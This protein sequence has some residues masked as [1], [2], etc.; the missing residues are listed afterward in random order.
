MLALWGLPMLVGPCS[1]QKNEDSL[2]GPDSHQQSP[3]QQEHF[4]GELGGKRSQ[5]LQRGVTI[6]LQYIADHLGNVRSPEKKRFTSWNRVRGTVDLDLGKLAG[7]E[8]WTFHITGLWQAGG[9]LGTDLNSIASPSGMSSGSTFRL[10]SYWVE[11]RWKGERI[12]A[13]IGQFAGQDFY[14][15]EHFA[16]SYIFEPMGYA[17]GNLNVNY[18][19]FDP[20][21]TPAAELRVVPIPHVYVKSMVFAADRYPYSHNN[22]GLVPQFRGAAMTVSEAGY[23]V[24]RKASTVRGLDTVADRVGYSG[25]Y[26]IG[27]TYNPGKFLSSNSNTPVS[28][29]FLVYTMATQALWRRDPITSKGLDFT[30]AS[31]W[32][33]ADRSRNNQQATVGLRYNE[34]LPISL[35]N[36]LSIGYVRSGLSEAYSRKTNVPFALH[37]EH[38]FEVNTLVELPRG[39]LIQPVFQYFIDLGGA[40]HNAAVLGFRSKVD[41]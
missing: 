13:R 3:A 10:D 41:F 6:D 31:N 1:A 28:G 9:N 34:L 32:S 14:G 22:T 17:M 29:N 16:A 37:A 2:S 35:H 30:A 12:T 19:S 39:I 38:A 25:L 24:G 7:A 26:Q 15:V 40:P 33:P 4:S 20:P 27:G 23:S 36:S 21:S 8:G 5:L 11:K 18:E